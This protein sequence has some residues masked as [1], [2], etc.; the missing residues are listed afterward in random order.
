MIQE[1]TKL[2]PRYSSLASLPDEDLMAEIQQGHSDA[3]AVLFDRYHRLV[4]H[5]AA[6]ILRDAS[7]A[8]DLM[9]SVFLEL[10]RSAGL[11]NKH[12]GTVKVWILQYAYS[13]SFNRRQHLSRRDAHELRSA[14]SEEAGS[15]AC[16][17]RLGPFESARAVNQAMN[18]LNGVQR[19]IIELVFYEGLTMREIAE[20]TDESFDSVRHHYY[21]G[22]EKLRSVL[23]EKRDIRNMA[24]EYHPEGVPVH[25]KS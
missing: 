11:F 5:V 25:V 13:R 15:P 17:S 20:K 6:R 8:E 18:Q 4:L 19:K 23:H 9:Q 16:I 2:P 3:I 22:M 12:R 10:L 14:P 24:E 21:R 7:E 1:N